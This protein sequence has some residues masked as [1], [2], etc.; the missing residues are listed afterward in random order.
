MKT[1]EN[2]K[3]DTFMESLETNSRSI[4]ETVRFW[5]GLTA[6]DIQHIDGYLWSMVFHQKFGLC[7]TFDMSLIKNYDFVQYNSHARPGIEII[8]KDQSK[9]KEI[10]VMLHTKH[11][12]PDAFNLNGR[13]NV[14]ISNEIKQ[15]YKIGIQKR[16]YTREPT[17]KVPCGKYEQNTCKS[18]E[19][20]KFILEKYQCKVPFLYAGHHLDDLISKD[21]TNCNDEIS[22]KALD[23][24]L[25]KAWT[26]LLLDMTLQCF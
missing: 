11:D 22:L 6:I 15:V 14:I 7:Y 17:R 23:F 19:N 2:F 25:D 13:Q 26:S 1:D 20:H 8:I 10:I 12:F 24:I 9:W 16:I 18:I 4:V 5:T 21:T 3:I